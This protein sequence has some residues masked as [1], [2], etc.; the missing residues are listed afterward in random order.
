[1]SKDRSQL[2]FDRILSLMC[3][4]QMTVAELKVMYDVLDELRV[5]ALKRGEHNEQ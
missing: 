4:S 2:L 3:A 5:L 1:M